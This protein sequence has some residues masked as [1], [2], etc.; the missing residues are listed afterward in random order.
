MERR[1]DAAGKGEREGEGRGEKRE[2]SGSFCRCAWTII[3]PPPLRSRDKEMQTEHREER[4]GRECTG[5]GGRKKE[6][7]DRGTEK[8]KALIKYPLSLRVWE[9]GGRKGRL[10]AEVGKKREEEEE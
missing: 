9:G 10:T 5:G 2:I 3:P 4:K 1:I 8:K 6:G 7:V